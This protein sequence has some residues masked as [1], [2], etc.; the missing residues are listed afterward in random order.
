MPLNPKNSSQTLTAEPKTRATRAA[1]QAERNEGEIAEAGEAGLGA[2]ASAAWAAP[3][4]ERTVTITAMR[5]IKE[6]FEEEAAIGECS[7]FFCFFFA[8]FS[9]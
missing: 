7:S 4:T 9:P 8:S 1:R 2:G 6:A 5:T 3:T